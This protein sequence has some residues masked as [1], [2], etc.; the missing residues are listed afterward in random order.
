MTKLVYRV[1]STCEKRRQEKFFVGVKG[2]VCATCRRAT[3]RNSARR[4]HLKDTYDITLEEY[5]AILAAQSNCCAACHGE[6]PYNL[7]VDHDHVIAAL[8]GIRASI[9]GLLCKRC[10]KTLRDVRDSDTL[11]RQLAAY[12]VQPPAR[13]VLAA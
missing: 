10:N 3:S 13:K 4:K 1:C 2:H 7:A 5:D 6:R 8:W 12:L 11:L 9:R